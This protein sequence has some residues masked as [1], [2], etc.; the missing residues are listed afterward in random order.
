MF[1][2]LPNSWALGM[3]LSYDS[4]NSWPRDR[5]NTALATT[6]LIN[7]SGRIPNDQLLQIIGACL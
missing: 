3:A 6:L 1:I 2:K 7:F 4:R 5:S